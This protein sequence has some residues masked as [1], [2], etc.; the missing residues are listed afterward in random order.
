MCLKKSKLKTNLSEAELH[1]LNS[2]IQNKNVKIQKVDQETTLLL[3]IMMPAKETEPY[4]FRLF[5]I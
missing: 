1:A 2:L 5:E 3:L 4:R